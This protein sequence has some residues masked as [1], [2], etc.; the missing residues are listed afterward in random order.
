MPTDT[1]SRESSPSLRWLLIVIIA[2]GVGFAG[3]RGPYRSLAPRETHQGVAW[4]F[5][6]VFSLSRAW[7][8]GANPYELD[9]VSRAWRS[10]NGDPDADPA[11]RRSVGILV[12]PPST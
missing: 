3:V 12:Y 10:S 8:F 5:G 9:G 11:I 4:D 2:A 6:L 7:I 1:P